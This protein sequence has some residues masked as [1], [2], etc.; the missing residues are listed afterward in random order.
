M[1][2]KFFLD[3]PVAAF[4]DQLME[5]YESSH[6]TQNEWSNTKAKKSKFKHTNRT[7]RSNVFL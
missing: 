3:L 6:D 5:K 4:T 7:S 2:Y 1:Q